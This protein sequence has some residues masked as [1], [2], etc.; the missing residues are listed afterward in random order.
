METLTLELSLSA[1]DELRKRAQQA[2]KAPEAL[3]QEILEAALQG[4]A[5]PPKTAREILRAAG[6]LT[7]LSPELRARIIPGVTLGEVRASLSR[8]G[9][10]SLSE[11]VDQ[12]RGPKA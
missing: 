4:G 11:I 10:P 5:S 1:Y 6:L 7:E 3:S 2:G 12:Q 9:G 8:A